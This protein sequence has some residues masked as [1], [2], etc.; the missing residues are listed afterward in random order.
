M[1]LASTDSQGDP[2]F[3]TGCNAQLREE[4]PGFFGHI[5]LALY[6]VAPVRAGEEILLDY[7]DEYW[8]S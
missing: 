2:A 7:G 4:P 8:V 5:D 3:A 6:L 1:P